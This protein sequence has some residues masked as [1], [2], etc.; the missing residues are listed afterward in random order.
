MINKIRKNQNINT[1]FSILYDN[2][3]KKDRYGSLLVIKTPEILRKIGLEYCDIVID[4]SKLL[5]IRNS[6]RNMT[7]NI[8]KSLPLILEY[9]VLV[10]NS[11]S[12]NKKAQK[13]KVIFG[14][15]KDSTG[16]PVLIAL[17]LNPIEN[18]NSLSKIYKIASAYGKENIKSIQK[19]IDARDSII[20]IDRQKNR[21]I[22]WL[23]ELGLQLPVSLTNK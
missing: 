21:T 4:K 13:R 22:N 9:P 7:D 3:D 5:Q 16:N 20:Y 11:Q 1:T 23:K 18:K 17:E 14:E 8:I 6:H 15:V 12:Q 2:W 10:L 19:W